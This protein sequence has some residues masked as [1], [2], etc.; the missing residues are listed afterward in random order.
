MPIEVLLALSVIS[1][2]VVFLLKLVFK[3]RGKAVPVWVYSILLYVVSLG[4]AVVFFPVQL[5]PFPP[6]SDLASGLAAL[7]TFLGELIPVLS[8]VVGAATTIYQI[9]LKKVLEGLGD[10]IKSLLET[11]AGSNIG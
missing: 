10:A 6:F 9:L 11:S 1:S 8:A 2:V 4:L 7:L 5:P 3:N